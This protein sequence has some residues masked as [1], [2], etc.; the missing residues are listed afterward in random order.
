M[1]I[2]VGGR[3]GGDELDKDYDISKSK[4]SYLRFVKVAQHLLPT[5]IN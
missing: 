1:V 2:V 3:D 5:S 4:S